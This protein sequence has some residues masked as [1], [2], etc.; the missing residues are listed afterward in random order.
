MAINR[1]EKHE[2]ALYFSQLDSDIKIGESFLVDDTE[3]LKRISFILRL[4]VNDKCVFF[5]TKISAVCT[6]MS[7]QK[8]TFLCFVN[9][10]SYVQ[11]LQPM[12]TLIVPLLKK[13]ALES[14]IYNATVMGV[15]DIQFVITEKSSRAFADKDFDRF[16]RI[17]IS[18]AEQSKQFVLPN[19]L[20]AVPLL[21]LFEIEKKDTMLAL[22]AD[23]E[24]ISLKELILNFSEKNNFI[25]SVGP[26]GDLSICERDYL[27]QKGFYFVKLISSVLRSED[28]MM[29]LM[30]IVRSFT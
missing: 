1:K 7:I 6:I 4:S 8:K 13:E 5:N 21:Q 24:G 22:H 29:L 11:S 14:L 18:A 10:I 20:K 26:E 30:G 2:F 23:V 3:L 15:K 19:F 9:D 28:A 16:K 17:A 27:K 12:I 25:L